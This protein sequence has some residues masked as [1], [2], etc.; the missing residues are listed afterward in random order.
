MR[1]EKERGD[2]QT[3]DQVQLG[4]RRARKITGWVSH[5]YDGFQA[6]KMQQKQMWVALVSRINKGGKKHR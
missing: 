5:S 3:S 6:P 1:R 4:D 2:R